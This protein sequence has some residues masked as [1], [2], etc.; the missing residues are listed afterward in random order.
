MWLMP[1]LIGKV[2]KMD[3]N[4]SKTR[5]EREEEHTPLWVK[6]FGGTILSIT[7]LCVLTLTGY[8]INNINNLQ[9]QVN[10][11]NSNLVTKKEFADQQKN[12]FDIM[13]IDGDNIV[14][15]KE[16][17]NSF[18]S[19]TRERQLLIEKIEN[20]FAEED[21]NIN[22][23]IIE[24]SKNI[25]NINKD[26]VALKE[27]IN[28]IDAQLIQ[29]REEYRNIQKDIQSLREKFAVIEGKSTEK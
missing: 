15:L 1:I 11:I 9:S 5:R 7:F 17:L 12:I 6:I 28:G 25:E 27:R 22:L 2:I 21:K 24:V 19:L 8:I 29:F 13:K 10:L 26:F 20:K 4:S 23:K 18:E 14:S 16:K 3:D